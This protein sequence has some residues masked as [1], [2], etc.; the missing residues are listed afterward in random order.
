MFDFKVHD[1]PEELAMSHASLEFQDGQVFMVVFQRNC[2]GA[3]IKG[4]ENGVGVSGRFTL[5]DYNCPRMRFDME[6]YY[7]M[8][9]NGEGYI[10][11]APE[12]LMKEKL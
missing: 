2:F 1:V 4:T 11:V 9:S 5:V 3:K 6:G 12:P 10:N 8:K 7:S